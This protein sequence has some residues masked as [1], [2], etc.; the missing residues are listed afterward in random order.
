MWLECPLWVQ[1]L[2]GGENLAGLVFMSSGTASLTEVWRDMSG[3]FVL[4]A[5]AVILWPASSPPFTS[6]R[7]SRPL[8]EIADAA[9]EFDTA[10]LTSG[11]TWA[12]G[13]MR[14]VNWPKPSTPWRDPVQERGVAH[15]VHCQCVP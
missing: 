8:K 10:N 5:C 7:Q 11:W 2:L 12:S 1:T 14:L 15:E 6:H 3:I 9:R 4:S 13:R